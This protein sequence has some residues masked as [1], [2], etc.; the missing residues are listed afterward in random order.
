MRISHYYLFGK[1]AFKSLPALGKCNFQKALT[2][3]G[4]DFKNRFF[5][6]SA[7]I[8]FFFKKSHFFW[9]ALNS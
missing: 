2:E 7:K 4:V 5:D 6:F 8:D 9:V 1:F 3:L